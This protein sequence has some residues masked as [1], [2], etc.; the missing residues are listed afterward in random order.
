MLPIAR[1][2]KIKK[3]FFG[4]TYIF[5]PAVGEVE[6]FL[7]GST[8]EDYTIEQLR[9]SYNSAVVDLEKEYKGKRKPQKKQWEKLLVVR[10]KTYL[11]DTGNDLDAISTTIDKVLVGWEIKDLP[12]PEDGKPSNMLQLA[13]KTEIYNW[14]WDTQVNLT[15]SEAKN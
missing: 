1:D 9:E 11:P 14:Y 7:L 6:K 8:K 13:L 15:A 2:A 3:D 5:L 10:Q 4:A 12:F